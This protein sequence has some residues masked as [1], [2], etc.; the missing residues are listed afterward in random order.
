MVEDTL[1]IKLSTSVDSA[2]EAEELLSG[3]DPADVKRLLGLAIQ[4]V[5]GSVAYKCHT[6]GARER[7][8]MLSSLLAEY[9]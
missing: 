4:Q 7:A 6:N 3:K 5:Q 9:H 8:S 1:L 2:R